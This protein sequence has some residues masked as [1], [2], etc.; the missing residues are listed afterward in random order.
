MKRIIKGDKV[1]VITGKWKGSE[2]MVL[3]ILPK[4]NKVIVEKVNLVKCHLKAGKTQN[5]EAG[6]V[7]KEAPIHLSNVTLVDPKSKGVYTKVGFQFDK[8]N[9]KVRINR[10]TN[11]AI[12]KA[13]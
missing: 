3:A 10:K 9:H 6:I 1:R 7:E 13:K 4:T 12:A 5:Q 8:N 11:T 2:G